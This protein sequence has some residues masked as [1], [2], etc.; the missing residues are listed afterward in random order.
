MQHNSFNSSRRTAARAP[1]LFPLC[2]M[3]TGP[4]IK[5]NHLLSSGVD[6]FWI[7]LCNLSSGPELFQIFH[8]LSVCGWSKTLFVACCQLSRQ[9]AATT[10]GYNLTL[11]H[12]TL[13]SSA[14][15]SQLPSNSLITISL[16]MNFFVCLVYLSILLVWLL[17]TEFLIPEL[18]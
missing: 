11:C 4:T 18:K 17:S 1:L 15:I 16:C 10:A 14:L 12:L 8:V 9:L 3:W 13:G 6:L 5:Q 2:Q 7:C